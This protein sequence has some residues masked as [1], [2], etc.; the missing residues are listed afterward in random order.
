MAIKESLE[1]NLVSIQT[2]I[3]TYDMK[4]TLTDRQEETYDNLDAQVYDVEEEVEI[5]TDFLEH[6]DE[7]ISLISFD[8]DQLKQRTAKLTKFRIV[9]N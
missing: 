8:L 9:P 1:E 4:D 7:A 2:R 5:A 6:I 3:D